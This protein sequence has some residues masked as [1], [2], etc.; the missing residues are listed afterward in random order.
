M[1]IKRESVEFRVDK[2]A[3]FEKFTRG[4][5]GRE[6]SD[7]VNNPEIKAYLKENIVEWA[8]P[9]IDEI[10]G[11]NKQDAFKSM[12]TF[13]NVYYTMASM[14]FAK[15]IEEWMNSGGNLDNIILSKLTKSEFED[16][17][18]TFKK[19]FKKLISK[20]ESVQPTFVD[21]IEEKDSIYVMPRVKAN[22]L[23]N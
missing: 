3:F 12:I 17:V 1:E 13:D 14:T 8:K 22:R 19:S 23:L 21:D 2:N 15:A 5:I 11:V 18:K 10:I 16:N 7:F 6:F 9:F 4:K 20:I